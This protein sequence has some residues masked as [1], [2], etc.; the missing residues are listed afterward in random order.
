MIKI[1]SLS[2]KK[3]FAYSPFVATAL[4][5]LYLTI[6]LHL[7]EREL[8]EMEGIYQEGRINR[9]ILDMEELK[10]NVNTFALLSFY[11]AISKKPNWTREE[12]VEDINRELNEYFRDY[13][14]VEVSGIEGDFTVYVERLPDNHLLLKTNKTPRACINASELVLCSDLS[15]E[16]IID[17]KWTL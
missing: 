17:G 12:F 1:I 5:L 6:Y 13:T 15:V 14:P 3:G 10:S 9:A 4:I 11:Q 8:R 16:R 2:N 7:T